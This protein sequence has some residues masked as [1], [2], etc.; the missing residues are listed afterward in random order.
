MN[1]ATFQKV[2]GRAAFAVLLSGGPAAAQICIDIER[3]D[4]S[5]LT[6][7]DEAALQSEIAPTLGCLGLE[8]LNDILETVTLA[9]IDAGYVAARAF[10]PEQDLSDGVLDIAVIEGQVS[11]VVVLQNGT[12]VKG[13]QITAFPGLAGEPLR[14]PQL[15]QGLAQINR[16]GSSDAVSELSPGDAPGDTVV[17]VNVAQDKQWSGTIALDNRGTSVTGKFNF[18]LTLG[19]ENLLGLNDSW[20]FSLQR[21]MESS[22]LSFGVSSP[23]GNAYSLSGSIPF[24]FWTFGGSISASD[25]VIDIL[26]LTTPIEASGE[27]LTIQLSA[28]RLLSI[29]ESGRWDAGVT[30]RWN[31]NENLILGTVIDTASR[32]LSVLDAYVRRSQAAF[33]G[34]LDAVVTL[35]QGLDIF[36]AFDDDT[37]PPGSPKA[38]YTALLIEASYRR[39]WDIGGQSVFLSSRFS[40]QYS[41]DSLFGSEQFSSG[42]FSSVRGS[43]DSL[44]FGNSGVQ[45]INTISLPNAV[46]LGENVFLT[47][48]VGFDFGHAFGETEF[49]ID[50]ETLISYAVGTTLTGPNFSIDA[51]YGRIIDGPDPAEFSKSGLF[52]IQARWSF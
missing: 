44:L 22:P 24:G 11:D 8:G 23:V 9:Y 12:P 46:E 51:L 21:S 52:T 39:N 5:G 38:Q 40:G 26:G 15:E 14:L 47:P 34:Q 16:L 1:S 17:T 13:R 32:R 45:L 2:A 33:G 41:G 18:G 3:V 43:R 25:Y 49:G 7:I 42:G 19:Y 27:N 35:R 48:Y 28:E 29:S 50:D 6:L 20:L 4:F 10:L 37:A 36:D 30:L 31:D